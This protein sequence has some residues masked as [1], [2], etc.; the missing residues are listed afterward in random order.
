MLEVGGDFLVGDLFCIAD[1]AIHYA[2]FLGVSL[3][4]DERYKPNCKRYLEALQERPAFQSAQEKQ[5]IV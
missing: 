3:G 5:L 2:L 4:L 1:I